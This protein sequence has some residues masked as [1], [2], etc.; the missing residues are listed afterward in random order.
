M[1]RSKRLAAVKGLEDKR[2]E[3]V[4]RALAA[5]R[6]RLNERKTQLEKLVQYM[7]EY[8]KKGQDSAEHNGLFL[9][10][11]AFLGRLDAAVEA[12]RT[13]V[14][15]CE[16]ECAALVERWHVQRARARALESAGKR[17][18]ATAQK[19]LDRV[20]Q[21]NSDEVGARPESRWSR[22]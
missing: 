18:Q 7:D 9:E 11:R 5:A 6:K 13:R 2:V 17:L 10:R 14:S 4:A 8:K 3:G 22:D 16:Q 19:R 21:S 1:E 12:A 20:E 15:Q